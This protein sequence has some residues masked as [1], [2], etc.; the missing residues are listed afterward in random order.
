MFYR[1]KTVSSAY[2]FMGQC[3]KYDP[4]LSLD[5]TIMVSKSWSV[6]ALKRSL[7]RVQS[8]LKIASYYACYNFILQKKNTVLFFNYKALKLKLT[9]L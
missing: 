1:F 8:N 6:M 7:H 2:I 9:V 5:A 4:S 3:K